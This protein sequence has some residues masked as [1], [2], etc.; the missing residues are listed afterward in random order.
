MMETGCNEAD[1]SFP[2]CDCWENKRRSDPARIPELEREIER[3][4]S[5]YAWSPMETCPTD[6]RKILIAVWE[7]SWREPRRCRE[8]YSVKAAGPRTRPPKTYRTEEGEDYE[9]SHWAPLELPES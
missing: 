5:L 9:V 7:G 3:L 6:G 4:R 8:V 1:C 2:D